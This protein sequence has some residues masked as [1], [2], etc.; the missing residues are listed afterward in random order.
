MGG[1]SAARLSGVCSRAGVV[2]V[3]P[4]LTE[5][6]R[7]PSVRGVGRIR[8]AEIGASGDR[9]RVRRSGIGRETAGATSGGRAVEKIFRGPPRVVSGG[10]RRGVN[11][12]VTA[13]NAR[14][15]ANNRQA[16]HA[17]SPANCAAGLGRH[18]G[19]LYAVPVRPTDSGCG[20]AS[21]GR[22]GRSA[23]GR[24][25]TERGANI[26]W[27]AAGRCTAAGARHGRPGGAPKRGR[28]QAGSCGQVGS[29]GR[30]IGREDAAWRCC[31]TRRSAS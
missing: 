20:S 30:R 7:P 15:N 18:Y 17:Q 22:A 29:G 2:D 16:L 14:M 13:S 28:Q 5:T 8:S 23:R 31:A 21:W 24:T 4:G 12:A 19:L 6:D 26:I 3:R 1:W 10:A 27:S 25:N 11:P 9:C